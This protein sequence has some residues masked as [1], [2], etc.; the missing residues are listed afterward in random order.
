MMKNKDRSDLARQ[1]RKYINDP[2]G[3]FED[4]P[5]KTFDKS[6]MIDEYEK[7]YEE[8]LKSIR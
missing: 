1:I 4:Q 3:C 7:M 8:M 2:D 6:R 5:E